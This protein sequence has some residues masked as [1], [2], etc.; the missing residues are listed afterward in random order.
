MGTFLARRPGTQPGLA[1]HPGTQ[2]GTYQVRFWLGAQE[3]SPE[4]TRY[5]SGSAPKNAARIGSALRNA[6]R[7]V[8]GTFLARRPGTQPGTYQVRFWFR[9]Q[10][11]SQDWL[12]TQERSQERT[13][14]VFGSAPRNAAR[15]VPGTFLARRPGTQPGTYQ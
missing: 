2:P 5:V 14:Y 8:P 15:N 11:R 13:R 6:P 3:R 9:A 1:R 7:N 12:G 10:E 4:R